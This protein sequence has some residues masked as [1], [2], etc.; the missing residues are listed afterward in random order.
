MEIIEI[1]LVVLLVLA[2]GVLTAA[3]LLQKS[4]QAG[5]SSAIAGSASE[6]HISGGKGN[7]KNKKLNIL[8]IALAVFFVIVVLACYIIQPF[9]AKPDYGNVDG[10]HT[11]DIT[12]TETPDSTTKPE[13]TTAAPGTTATPTTSAAPSTTAAPTTTANP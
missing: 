9:K 11:A 4:N 6:N 13:G 3:V 1:I 12:T 10:Q 8:V 2:A 7:A 5:M